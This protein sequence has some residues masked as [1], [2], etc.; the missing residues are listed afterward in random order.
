MSA[1]TQ[2]ESTSVTQVF[3]EPGD[4]DALSPGS[5][6]HQLSIHNGRRSWTSSP[7]SMTS[8]SDDEMMTSASSPVS[9]ALRS[10]GLAPSSSS[11][12]SRRLMNLM[13]MNRTE[14]R[15][16]R[17]GSYNDYSTDLGNWADESAVPPFMGGM[18]G[19]SF[20]LF[21]PNLGGV[22]PLGPGVGPID[23]SAAFRAGLA[24][25]R[26]P[27]SLDYDRPGMGHH[28][29]SLDPLSRMPSSNN[30]YDQ[31]DR[32]SLPPPRHGGSGVE[33]TGRR[34]RPDKGP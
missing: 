22:G 15:Q 11:W 25:S 7:N 28:H 4:G 34:Y 8:T 5:V 12:R 24:V 27:H 16:R 17:A 6:S 33:Y 20:P 23:P 19:M 10:L 29:P 14:A 3:L 32:S 18:P 2:L 13:V 30:Y 9:S 21:A 26:R 31:K 1:W